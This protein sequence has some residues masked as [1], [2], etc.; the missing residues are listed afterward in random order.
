MSLNGL[1]H[2]EREKCESLNWRWIRAHQLG[3]QDMGPIMDTKNECNYGNNAPYIS[4]KV[5]QEMNMGLPFRVWGYPNVTQCSRLAPLLYAPRI[6]PNP[7]S[8]NGKQHCTG[9]KK[10]FAYY[11]GPSLPWKG[12]KI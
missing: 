12:M 10:T 11:C 9:D 8:N 3:V 2:P 6:D 7:K 1:V 4:P 5:Q